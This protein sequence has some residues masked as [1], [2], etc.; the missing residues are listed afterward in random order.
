MS[1]VGDLLR[2]N[3]DVFGLTQAEI[4]KKVRVSEQFW[5]RIE[6]GDVLLPIKRAAKTAAVLKIGTSALFNA[7]VE[8]YSA[9]IKRA[10][11]P[12]R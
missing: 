2:E 7:Y 9:K 5:G 3:R 4:A 12:R 10:L 1:K 6:K 11:E 8:D